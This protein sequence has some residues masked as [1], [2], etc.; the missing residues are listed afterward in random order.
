M[1]LF[2]VNISMFFLSDIPRR[3]ANKIVSKWRGR[4]S[5][6]ASGLRCEYIRM[7]RWWTDEAFE[8]TNMRIAARHPL[9]K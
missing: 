3:R 2:V 8:L 7:A 5:H 4:Q 9:C 1:F 6:I